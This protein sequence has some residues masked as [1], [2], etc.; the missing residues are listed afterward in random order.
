MIASPSDVAVERQAIRDLIHEWNAIN[1]EDRRIVLMPVAWDTHASPEMGD[2][3]QAL[4]NKQVLRDC[5][6]LVA[7][8]WTRIGSPTGVSASGTVEEIEEHLAGGR[9]AMVYFSRVPVEAGSVDQEQYS[10]LLEFRSA[11]E[12]RGLIEAYDSVQEFRDKFRRQLS[13]K[14]IQAYGGETREGEFAAQIIAEP[15]VVAMSVEARELLDWAA[16]DKDGTILRFET[17]G[18]TGIQTNRRQFSEMGNPRSE[19][20]WTAAL[21]ELQQLDL[22]EAIG[23]KNQVFRVTDEGYRVADRLRGGVKSD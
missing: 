12:G 22:V 18:G 4:I 8:F 15:S 5:D 14:I 6:L 16:Q 19:A 20:K 1:S 17:M 7:V 11:C 3:P 10:A 21:R 9:Q 13:Q 2:R 23:Y